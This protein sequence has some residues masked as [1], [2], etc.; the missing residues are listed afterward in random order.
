MSSRPSWP[1]ATPYIKV[2]V[3]ALDVNDHEAVPRVFRRA[4]RRTRRDRPRGR[5]RRH[6]RLAA[7]RGASR[8]LRKATLRPT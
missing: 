8:G 4:V 3:A 5:Q 6:R 2:A 1:T 7:G